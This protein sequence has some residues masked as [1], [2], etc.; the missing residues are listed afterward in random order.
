MALDGLK[1]HSVVDLRGPHER[2]KHPSRRSLNFK[3]EILFEDDDTAGMAPHLEAAK[4]GNTP[5]IAR[6]AM[7]RGYAEMPFRP[8]LIAIFRRYFDALERLNGASLIHC[9]A[10][11]DR[12]GLAVALFHDMVGVQ[13]DD[14]LKD[15]LL[16]NE[17]GLV[18]NWLNASAEQIRAASGRDVRHDVL[19]EILSVHPEYLI[20]AFSEIKSRHGSLDSYRQDVLGVTEDRRAAILSKVIA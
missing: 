15:Y 18:E 8:A 11:K 16:T 2:D 12:T 14:L 19:L 3:G 1:L 9:M 17:S 7:A 10:G 13:W 5:E 4:E 20:A 6:K